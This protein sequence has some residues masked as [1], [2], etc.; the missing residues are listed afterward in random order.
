MPFLSYSFPFYFHIKKNNYSCLLLPGRTA[1]PFIFI[2][3]WLSSFAYA[4]TNNPG[5]EIIG[6]PWS[7][8][9]GITESIQQIMTRQGNHIA[10]PVSKVRETHPLLINPNHSKKDNPGAPAVSQW[11][12][13]SRS[14]SFSPAN[15]ILSPQTVGT[16]F[17]ATQLSESGYIPPD[18]VGAVGPSQILVPSNGV[19]KVFDRSGTVGSLNTTLENFF[20]SVGGLSGVSD[21]HVRYDRLTGRWFIVA[22]SVASTPNDV[23]IAV[24]NSSTITNSSSFT[25]FQ[26]QHDLVGTTPNT[27]T[28]GFADYPT[29][30]VDANA[31][32]IGMNIFNAAGDTLYGTTAYVVRKS[33]LISSSLVV[34]AFRQIGAAGGTGDGPWTPQGVDNDD[35]GATEGYFIGVDDSLFSFLDVRRVSSPGGTPTLSGNLKISVPITRFPISVP[36]PGGSGTNRLDA[37]DDRL[38]AA[39]IFKNKITGIS[40][41]W[42]AHNIQVNSSGVGSTSGGRNGSRWYEIGNLS[43]TPTLVQSGTLFDASASTPLSYWI[44]SVAMSGQ[45]HMSIGTSRAN[46]TTSAGVAVAGRFSDDASGT[47]QT[48]TTA[49]T[50]A[51][52]YTVGT[53]PRRWGDYSQTVVDPNDNQTIWTFQEYVNATNSW[54]VRVVELQAPPPATPSAAV[55]SV[56]PP[57]SSDI[58][59]TVTGTSSNS[60]A[61]FDPG[62]DTGGPGFANRIAASVSGTGVNVNSISFTDPTHVILNISIDPDATSGTRSIT[63]TNP[64]G[65]STTSTTDIITI[66]NDAYINSTYTSGSAGGHVWQVDAFTKVQDGI[67][68]L[69]DG[70]NLHIASDTYNET[71]TVSKDLTFT[72]NGAAGTPAIQKL[73]LRGNKTLTLENDFSITDTLDLSS[74]IINTSTY[75]L[76]LDSSAS[77]NGG[78]AAAYINGTVEHNGTGDKFFPIGYST[79]YRP[80]EVLNVTGASPVIRFNVKSGGGGSPGSGLNNISTI[81]YWEGSATGFST[82]NVKLSW[83]SDDGVNGLSSDLRVSSSATVDG[84]YNDDGNLEINGDATSGTVTSQSVNSIGFFRLASASGDQPLPVTF[85]SFNAEPA[86]NKVVLTWETAS[87]IDNLGY[88]ISRKKRDTQDWIFLNKEIIRGQGNTSSVSQYKY[89]DSQV[90]S[91]DSYSYKLESVAINGAIEILRTID[92][93]IPEPKQFTLFNNYPNPFNPETVINYQLAKDSYVTIKI[94]EMSGKEIK[95]LVNEPQS[96]GDH[97]IVF[98]STGLASGVYIYKIVAG[99]FIRA[100]KMVLLR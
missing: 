5:D 89:I 8:K 26:Y 58:S 38:F 49:Q 30:G 43:T 22:I 20:A 28:G 6:I 80:I 16:S 69:L 48:P 12:E 7:G 53:N 42:T 25:F 2:L 93:E 10:I 81:R 29:L 63:V 83:G 57:G 70:G 90:K 11:P 39:A 1:I 50:G 40:S 54:G 92:V 18:V 99:K 24:S 41:L 78:S 52:D 98:N 84:I 87:E 23:L 72:I 59:L 19:I 86:F 66:N 47:L 85:S 56:L 34:T 14:R 61:F 62:D 95:T 27:D 73:R 4:Q 64:D 60:S 32:Y 76:A 74:G 94:F 96:A 33:A 82:G 44:P 21:P 51:G 9:P 37:L 97:K 55:P 71:D 17:L 36:H 91:G 46:R 79:I 67:D 31:L 35:P 88:N 15:L 3:T 45:G 75:I 68:A 77:I 65:Q 100:K 13:N